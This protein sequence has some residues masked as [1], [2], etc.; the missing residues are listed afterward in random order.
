MNERIDQLQEQRVPERWYGYAHPKGWDDIII[1][2]DEQIAEIDPDYQLLQ[3]KQ[4][5]GGLRYYINNSRELS[6]EE[7]YKIR[8]LIAD[9]EQRS[10]E[11]CEWCGQPGEERTRVTGWIYTSCEEH[12]HDR[13]AEIEAKLEEETE[14][15]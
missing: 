6:D 3:S 11:T 12:T 7:R 15:S 9:A 13:R 8:E 4:K 2:L 5:F 1:E 10:R 14:S